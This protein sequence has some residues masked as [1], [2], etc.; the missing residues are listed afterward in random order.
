M[1]VKHGSN[2]MTRLEQCQGHVN[3]VFYYKAIVYQEYVR[4]LSQTINKEEYINVLLSGLE[5]Y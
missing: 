1:F 2:V 5:K 3:S 4:F